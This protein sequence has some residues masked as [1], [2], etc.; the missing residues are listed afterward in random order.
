MAKKCVV[1]GCRSGKIGKCSLFRFPESSTDLLTNKLNTERRKRWL[2]AL[3]IRSD[4]KW[5]YVCGRHFVS[6]KPARLN[7]LNDVDWVPTKEL[8]N[9]SLK[10]DPDS[11]DFSSYDKVEGQ[12]EEDTMKAS[13]EAVQGSESDVLMYD[14]PEPRP[15]QIK[16]NTLNVPTEEF[17][18]TES[19]T[20][21]IQHVSSDDLPSNNPSETET[22]GSKQNNDSDYQQ[23]DDHTNV[24]TYSMALSTEK[25][26]VGIQAGGVCW[27]KEIF[28]K[29]YSEVLRLQARNY[30]LESKLLATRRGLNFINN[31][32]SCK[33]FTGVAK[34]SVLFK[35]YKYLE[36]SLD[37]PYCEFSKDQMFL[38][39]L[40]KLRLN[41]QLTSLAHD[42]NVSVTTISKY[43]HRTLY[44]IYEC[45]KWAIKPTQKSV[46]LRHTPDKFVKQFGSR[47]VYIIDCF[48]VMCQ[49][50]SDLKAACSHYS[51]Y[52]KHETVKFL[53]AM[54]PDGTVAFISSG[55]AGRCS[56]KEI[57][58]QSKFIDLV[59]EGDVVLADKGFDIA[60]VIA[61]KKAILNIPNFLRKKKQFSL[62]ELNDD[63][64][65]TTHRI[66]V[67]R[68][69]GNIREKYSILS[70]TISVNTL[71]RFQNGLTVIDLI[72][73]VACILVS[74]NK[75]IIH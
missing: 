48:E 8:P 10:F 26:D 74:L 39:T 53:I 63:K 13:D 7:E 65:I 60:D 58:R 30:E 51:N 5:N 64:Q 27:S 25:K 35:L 2:V 4:P 29:Y 15:E 16:E 55:F 54:N 41:S 71:A 19:N 73:K 57:F 37:E 61:S 32:Q 22:R 66:H 36:S 47:R 68:I 70:G 40:T 20:T 1:K 34:F 14:A 17:S 56:D 28:Q 11:D 6:G 45:C 49:T 43:F 24:A 72:V 59:D 18:I 46:V 62:N 31:D 21:A 75:P 42:Y 12:D 38:M 9:V 69:I 33:Y 52:K 23:F 67:E 3:R 50:P 44:I